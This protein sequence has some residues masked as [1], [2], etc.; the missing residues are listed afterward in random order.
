P[1]EIS[2]IVITLIV[3]VVG[4]IWEKPPLEWK[5]ILIVCALSASVFSIVKAFQDERDKNFTRKA[6][7][8][9]VVPTNSSYERLARDVEAVARQRGLNGDY[10]CPHSPDGLTCFW[11]SQ[12]KQ[13]QATFVFDKSEVADMYMNLI[14]DQ[15]NSSYISKASQKSYASKN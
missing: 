13:K 15:S 10:N 14:N 5:V 7:L 4:T 3:A 12:D 6:L 1:L 11:S 9:L 8:T 2:L